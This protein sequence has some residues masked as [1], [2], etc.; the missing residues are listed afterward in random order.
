MSVRSFIRPSI[1]FLSQALAHY[2]FLFFLHVKLGV[3]KAN[4]LTA[5][6]ISISFHFISG[7]CWASGCRAY[8]LLDFVTSLIF[9]TNWIVYAFRK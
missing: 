4:E 8:P 3:R 6:F 5:C 7:C 9:C 2:F 1:H